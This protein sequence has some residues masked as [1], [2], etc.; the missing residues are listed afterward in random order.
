MRGLGPITVGENPMDGPFSVHQCWNLGGRKRQVPAPLNTISC[1]S[2]IGHTPAGW[3]ALQDTTLHF[4]IPHT[5]VHIVSPSA[6]I[7]RMDA[8]A[9]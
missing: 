4:Y 7:D 1:R 5:E 3:L 6:A 9:C 8:A 2:R